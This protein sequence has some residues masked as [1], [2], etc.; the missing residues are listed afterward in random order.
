MACGYAYSVLGDFHLAE[1]AAQEAFVDAYRLL[2]KLRDPEAFGGWLRRIIYKHCDRLTRRRRPQVSLDSVD[3]IAAKEPTPAAALELRETEARVRQAINSLSE[4][5]RQVIALFYVQRH[6]QPDIA[7]FLEVPL[8]TVK[9]RLVDARKKLKERML[10]MVSEAL[11]NN[12]PDE[13]FSQN[14]I[15]KLLNKP[16]PIEISGHPVRQMWEGIQDALPEWEVIDG[17]EVVDT[18]LYKSVQREMDMTGKCYQIDE[19]RILRSH[20]T[21]TAFQ[22]LK[23]REAPLRMLTAGRCFRPQ[24]EDTQRTRVFHQVDAICIDTGIDRIALEAVFSAMLHRLIGPVELRWREG[25]FGFVDESVEIDCKHDG[26]WLE[27]AGGGMLK[28]AMLREAG[29]DPERVSGFAFGLGLE[30]LVQVRD[31]LEDIRDLWKPPYLK[32]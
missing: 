1:D 24:E 19:N 28:A 23:G 31:G 21:H 4:T 30:R 29:Y 2:G 5:Q 11:Q 32:D 22:A 10:D 16:K 9:K 8:T 25:D 7:A 12:S 20:T 3:G 18:T 13:R 26:D 17:D 6:S 27:V 15:A 14:V